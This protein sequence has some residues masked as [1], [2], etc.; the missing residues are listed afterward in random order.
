[1]NFKWSLSY[2]FVLELH[3]LMLIV[4]VGVFTV[5]FNVFLVHF[6]HCICCAVWP[7][8]SLHHTLALESHVRC[9]VQGAAWSILV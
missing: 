9:G 6:Y 5:Q 4:F 7:K 1:M 8:A 3:T 2:V